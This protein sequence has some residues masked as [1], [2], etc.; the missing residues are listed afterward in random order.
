MSDA[1]HEPTHRPL[2]G[3]EIQPLGYLIGLQFHP[4]IKLIHAKGLEFAAKLS[5]HVDAPRE[6]NLQENQ[7]TFSQPLGSTSRG[8]FQV[9]VKESALVLEAAFPSHPLEWFEHRYEFIISE[10]RKTF[11]PELLLE[12]SAG[13]RGT[14][15][16]DG[17]A[18]TFLATYVTK[19]EPNQFSPLGRPLHLFGIRLLM[20]P[21]QEQKPPEGKRKKAKIVRTVDWV[22]D[23]KA[24]SLLEDTG[25]LYL[26]ANGQWSTPQK[27][28]EKASKSVVGQL[29]TV[30]DF[31]KNNFVAFL[32]AKSEEGDAQ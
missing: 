26:E 2:T 28:D 17:D 8:V 1:E 11:T 22:A 30:S 4:P 21:F 18:R 27:W 20:P 23:V 24:E 29:A 25:K 3:A 9:V 16:I 14:L 32:T 15:Q 6:L 31:L 10:F 5:T 7:W 13:Y 19:V 12:S